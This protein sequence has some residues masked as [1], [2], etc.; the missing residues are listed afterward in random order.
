M[1]LPVHA[2]AEPVAAERP[3]VVEAIDYL[4]Q[5]VERLA[6][7]VGRLIDHLSSVL[8]PFGENDEA[9]PTAVSPVRV[10]LADAIHDIAERVD[11]VRAVAAAAL[12]RIEL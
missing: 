2:A 3:Q 10:P 12:D 8:R 1:S 9:K 5:N 6:Q 7:T 11:R 4:E